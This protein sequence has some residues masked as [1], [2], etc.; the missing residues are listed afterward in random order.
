[1]S[2]IISK[3]TTGIF[4][5][6]NASIITKVL[7]IVQTIILMRI[8]DPYDFGIVAISMSFILIIQRFQTIGFSE[9]IIAGSGAKVEDDE[10]ST[11]F[12]L[13]LGI[14]SLLYFSQL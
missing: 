7:S 8:L 13:R 10:L 12:V 11:L 6:F 5:I 4:Y 2:T 3:I 9:A 14:S 1:M